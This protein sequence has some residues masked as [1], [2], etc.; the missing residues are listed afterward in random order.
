MSQETGSLKAAA[1]AAVVSLAFGLALTSGASAAVP[2]APGETFITT[3]LELPE[4][5][6]AAATNGVADDDIYRS[7]LSS[8]GRY[9]AFASAA[10]AL[11]RAADPDVDNIYRKDRNTGE[12]VLVSRATGANGAGP[13]RISSDPRI[14]GDGNLVAFVTDAGLD[15]ADVDGEKDVYI[16][17]IGAGTTTLATPETSETV[18]R[19]DLSADGQYV[20]FRTAD[21]L[22]PGDGNT[23]TDIYRHKLGTTAF[24]LVS[25]TT[26]PL[27]VSGGGSAGD[28]S[29]SGDGRWVAFASTSES[30]VTAFLNNNGASADIF[31]RDMQ[32][33]TTYL[34]SRQFNVANAGADGESYEPRIAGTPALVGDVKIAFV[35]RAT[36]L[37]DAGV[38]DTSSATSVYLRSLSVNASVLISRNSSGDNADSRAHSPSISDDGNL[39]NFASDA[40]NL[41]P[42]PD[43]YAAYLR[44]VNTATTTQISADNEYA[45]EGDISGDGGFVTWVENGG[46]T[47]DSDPDIYNVFGRPASGGPIELVSRPPGSGA[48]LVP[49]AN[50]YN[51]ED[52]TR[53]ISADGRYIVFGSDSNR[54]PGSN[55]ER[56]TYRRDME[57]GEIELVSRASGAG[58]AVSGSGSEDASISADGSRVTFTSGAP[59]DPADSGTSNQVYLRDLDTKTTYLVSRQSGAAGAEADTDSYATSISGD[60]N[61]VAFESEAGNLGAPGGFDQVYV[62][63]IASDTTIIA[64]RAGGVAGAIADGESE[65]GRLSADGRRVAFL[66]RATNL[67]PDDAANNRDVYYRD[68]DTG[69]TLL[70]SR[71][72]GLA[73]TPATGFSREPAISADGNVVAFQTEDQTTAPEAGAWPPGVPQI[74]V[75]NVASG[76]NTLVSRAPGG[77]AA[78]DRA[79]SP[80]LSADGSV[81]SFETQADNLVAGLG[82]ESRG[83]VFVRD[84]ATGVLSG[85]PA[86]GL[87]DNEPQQGSRVPSISDNGQCLSFNAIG[88]NPASGDASD[89]STN[90]IYVVSGSCSNPRITEPP[91]VAK[92]K[93][94][95]VKITPKRFAVSGKKTAKVAAETRRR[96]ARRRRKAR[97]SVSGWTSTPG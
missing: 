96:R 33:N 49:A 28:V 26:A 54:L 90:Y 52:Y 78:N 13:A 27:S 44:N 47:P 12:V 93:L 86:F 62:R 18:D 57:T 76:Q 5:A 94:S 32:A 53:R 7:P 42:D 40:Q 3:Y 22:V 34:V 50:D 70:L 72:S 29:I 60:G 37:S 56:Q 75:R 85:P 6:T 87:I 84:M 89:V 43:Y 64:S 2:A 63:D 8:D 31:A 51:F 46:A 58:G 48:F 15:P 21:A 79:D 14:S 61:R 91:V 17:D 45:V 19:Y 67:S 55:G 97:R 4:G 38:S 66:S 24:S 25:R 23:T 35:S 80:S 88:Y 83:A 41:G 20:A 1:K 71:Q 77:A 16:R 92:P 68:L 10:N 30:L 65:Q 73:G 39:V 9:V 81:V 11:D 69:Q 74:V 82:G 36:N 95:K 59:L